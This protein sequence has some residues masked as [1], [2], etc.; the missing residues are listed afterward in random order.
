MTVHGPPPFG[1][2]SHRQKSCMH[3]IYQRFPNSVVAELLDTASDPASEAWLP[4][5]VF[6]WTI[7][8]DYSHAQPLDFVGLPH[9]ASLISAIAVDQMCMH[10]HVRH[11]RAQISCSFSAGHDGMHRALCSAN[12]PS[13]REPMATLRE[14]SDAH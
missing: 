10:G 1:P 7:T 3:G 9:F 5:L 6:A 4:F 12:V 14:I 8:L 13:R 11:A 2:M